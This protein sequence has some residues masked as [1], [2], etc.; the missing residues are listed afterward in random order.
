M[1][2]AFVCI[3]QMA[4]MEAGGI[5]G[6]GANRTQALPADGVAVS[7]SFDG[8]VLQWRMGEQQSPLPLPLCRDKRTRM[9]TRA[10]HVGMWGMTY[11]CDIHIFVIFVICFSGL[12][13][14]MV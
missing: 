9:H 1:R 8:E 3:F 4:E 12:Q 13:C 2:M 7:G 6:G 10:Q 11:E 5:R 14:V